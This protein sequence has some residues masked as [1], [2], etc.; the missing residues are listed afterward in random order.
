MTNITNEAIILTGLG[1]HIFAEILLK[2][3]RITEP[4]AKGVAIGTS[5]HAMG[6]AKALEIGEVEGAMSGLA[7]A[8][9]GIMTA[10]LVPLA[11]RLLT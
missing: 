10:V 5:A 3:F 1:G 11:A 9:A 7:I 8:A 4:V 6:T 2:L